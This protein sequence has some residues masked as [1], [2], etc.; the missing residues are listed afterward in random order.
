MTTSYTYARAAN[1]T[2]LPD[3]QV[4]A[5]ENQQPD[6]QSSERAAYF[7]VEGLDAMLPQ[8]VRYDTQMMV[9]GDTGIGKSVLA[10]QFLY[11]GLVTG[12]RC[13]YVA[14]DEPLNNMREHMAGFRLGTT[15]YER[16][17]QLLMLDAYGRELSQE[18]RVV[19]DPTNL[20]EFFLYQMQV[21]DEARASGGRVRMVVD[22]LSTPMAINPGNSI[23]D[24]NAHR[25]RYLR[26]RQ[27]LTLDNIV[28]NVLDE[29]TIA[30]LTH[31]YPLILR[32]SYRTVNGALA[33][34]IQLG[35]LKSGQFTANERA[36]TIDPR[37]GLVLQ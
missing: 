9:V 8:G 27:V 11:E 30:G 16:T 24:F 25:L 26:S 31:A 33:R 4:H 34:Y 14:C 28:A 37:T 23:V 18:A 17:G 35:K 21:V 32:M 3:A 12:D 2:I 29:R 7:G 20:D 5:L 10:A 19:P 15:A 1:Q 22:S 6:K 36:F 13:I